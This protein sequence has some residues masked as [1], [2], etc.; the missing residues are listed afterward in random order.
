[1]NK[2]TDQ[3]MTIVTIGDTC[4]QKEHLSVNLE[5]ME[6][7]LLHVDGIAEVY[8]LIQQNEIGLV[9]LSID[10]ISDDAVNEIKKIAER[11][12]SA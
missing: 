7:N 3:R 4:I 12:P 1:V 10:I 9:I 6:F 2:P 5:G 8:E 11:C